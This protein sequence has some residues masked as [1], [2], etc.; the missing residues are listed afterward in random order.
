MLFHREF[1]IFIRAEFNFIFFQL[2]FECINLWIYSAGFFN[3]SESVLS[4]IWLDFCLKVFYSSYCGMKLKR[5][6]LFWKFYENVT[7]RSFEVN[8]N[9]SRIVFRNHL[10]RCKFFRRFAP[11][12]GTK[13]QLETIENHWNYTNRL[14][15]L[16]YIN[17]NTKKVVWNVIKVVEKFIRMILIS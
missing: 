6:L 9:Y 17:Q 8:W 13:N 10:E 5:I 1:R 14:A 12:N 2:C 16:K 4:W 15:G 3:Y 11:N 7:C